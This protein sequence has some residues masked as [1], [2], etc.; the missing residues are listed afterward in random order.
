MLWQPLLLALCSCAAAI[1]SAPTAETADWLCVST[2]SPSGQEF[3]G[4]YRRLPPKRPAGAS[5]AGDERTWALERLHARC[6]AAAGSELQRHGGCAAWV[7]RDEGAWEVLRGGSAAFR[8]GGGGERL[9]ETGFKDVRTRGAAAVAAAAGDAAGD[10]AGGAAATTAAAAAAAAAATR[11]DVARAGG[12]AHPRSPQIVGDLRVHYGR[13]SADAQREE[14]RARLENV[15]QEK[16]Q[17]EKEKEREQE[18]EERQQ[19][20]E[21]TPPTGP[22]RLAVDMEAE[23]RYI[24]KDPCSA[25]LKKIPAVDP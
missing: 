12:G 11:P 16:E 17:Q 22:K 2:A 3:A 6:A 19:E 20:E 13:C 18:E 10:A 7:K 14:R 8:G 15:R 1:A 24:H 21:P 23:I 5:L 4:S 25:F 9:E